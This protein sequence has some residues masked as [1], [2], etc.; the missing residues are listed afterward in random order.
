MGYH[1]HV[2]WCA[3]ATR[4]RH[5]PGG[6]TSPW[7]VG[8]LGGSKRCGEGRHTVQRVGLLLAAL[9]VHLVSCGHGGVSRIERR[10]SFSSLL[11]HNASPSTSP[12]SPS[13]CGVHGMCLDPDQA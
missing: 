8:E 4:H 6:G 7:P 9:P 1:G 2:A 13:L 3:E 11:L 12:S 5:L 10:S